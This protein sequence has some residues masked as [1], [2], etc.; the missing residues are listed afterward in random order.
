MTNFRQL[1]QVL[2]DGGVEFI[3]VGGMAA[4]AHGSARVTQ[5]VDVVYARRT[6]SGRW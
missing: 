3:L 4:T 5:D 1:I 6:T 2:L